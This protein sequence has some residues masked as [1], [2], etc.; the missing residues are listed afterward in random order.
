MSSVVSIMAC[1][2][3]PAASLR[4][5]MASLQFSYTKKNSLFSRVKRMHKRPAAPGTPHPLRDRV[6][7]E[8]SRQSKSN[9]FL[10]LTFNVAMCSCCCCVS[11]SFLSNFWEKMLL[12]L[13]TTT[14]PKTTQHK[15]R[16]LTSIYNVRKG[17][18]DNRYIQN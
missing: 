5:R 18:I 16:S 14:S 8:T 7:E 12:F 9:K 13:R 6:P 11:N 2:K 17:F 10:F 3:R 15:K 1:E 4:R